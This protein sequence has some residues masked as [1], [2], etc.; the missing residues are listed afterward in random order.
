M[1]SRRR[2]R[3]R[4]IKRLL[5]DASSTTTPSGPTTTIAG[6]TT[7]I[8][9]YDAAVEKFA[10]AGKIVGSAK[11]LNLLP[12]LDVVRRDKTWSFG[13]AWHYVAARNGLLGRGI[14][15]VALTFGSQFWFDILRR[16]V[17]LRKSTSS[18]GSGAG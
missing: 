18:G 13:D 8:D 3:R 10:C 9:P 16:L 12:D 14:T 6:P 2:A 7:T 4:W 5:S 17:G 11:S 15:L 1:Q